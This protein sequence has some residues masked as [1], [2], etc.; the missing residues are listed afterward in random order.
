MKKSPINYY[1]LI[2]IILLLSIT[3][4]AKS[5]QYAG[6]DLSY[7]CIGGNTYRITLTHYRD[8]SGITAPLSM[9]IHFYCSSDTNNNYITNIP[10]V[11]NTG[12]EITPSCS[13]QPSSCSYGGGSEF[14]Y[15]YGVREFVYS[16]I[17]TLP[18]CA[19]WNIYWTGTPRNPI[20]TIVS[21]GGLSHIHTT[22]NS[23]IAFCNSSPIYKNNAVATAP[24]NNALTLDYGAIDPDGDSLVYSLYAPL[25]NYYP[26]SSFG[27]VSY[28]SPYNQYD[29]LS[30]S[31]PILL[32]SLTGIITCTPNVIQSTVIGVKIDQW[33][34]INGVQTLIGTNYR[35]SKLVIVNNNNAIPTLSGMDFTNSHTYNP[36]DSTYI[37][38]LFINT[39]IEF[40][41]NGYD[42]DSSNS[43]AIGSAE[44]FNIDWDNGITNATFTTYNNG[45]NSAYA[46]FSWL[47][48][49]SD[50]GTYT[51][52]VTIQD[53]A[54]PYYGETKKEYKI[55]IVSDI[56]V[57]LDIDS[58]NLCSNDSII[59]FAN[60]NLDS[61]IFEWR[62]NGII[63]ST[64]QNTDSIIYNSMDYPLGID[65]ITVCIK[66]PNSQ[67]CIDSDTAII[68]LIYQPN[69][70]DILGDTG[71]CVGSS[72]L[73]DAGEGA[74]YIW[75]R[76]LGNII[77]NNRTLL[78]S[79]AGTYNIFVNGKPNSRCIDTCTFEVSESIA[80]IV[81]LGP[82]VFMEYSD[83]LILDAG[84]TS[85]DYLWST[86]DTTPVIKI[87]GMQMMDD[88]NYVWV[89]VI[90]EYCVV[91]DSIEIIMLM[92][93]DELNNDAHFNIS[94]NPNNG[95]FYLNINDYKPGLIN[96]HIYNSLGKEVLQ[97]T[98]NTTGNESIKVNTNNLAKG[99][100]YFVIDSK[101][102]AIWKSTII[103][104]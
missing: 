4:T 29:F 3:N 85:Y 78:I 39:A 96:I 47:P 64:P 21:Y 60:T 18:P 40:D 12:Q 93:I 83:S 70:S 2:I 41:I 33:R 25:T 11:S 14:M 6:V 46:H 82:D 48:L 100:Y 54:C 36:N 63:I 7:T 28:N 61:A 73:L 99:A 38:T 72:I 32:D 51:F 45:T 59:I 66:S 13:Q 35:D 79:Q 27:T 88:S 91:R 30:S 77:S 87:Y 16:G 52:E 84:S 68:D 95:I 20:S 50:I 31:T 37:D 102:S 92:S 101:N 53:L 24:I 71:F 58:A 81:D 74:Q 9:E 34:E 62:R 19:D 98:I 8:C 49:I 1:I 97:K 89:D 69:L 67:N 15:P 90:N 23:T 76:G 104:Q 42:A 65:T 10:L 17:V 44:K 22:L 94:P 26:P 103:I 43:L 86:A 75:K 80:P 5:N 57:E 55:V 56:A